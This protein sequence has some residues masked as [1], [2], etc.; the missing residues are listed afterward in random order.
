MRPGAPHAQPGNHP[1]PGH[2]PAIENVSQRDSPI[3]S[4]ERNVGSMRNPASAL[5]S[6]TIDGILRMDEIR[7]FLARYF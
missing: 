5:K 7:V 4:M 3:S 2:S 1:I 6:G